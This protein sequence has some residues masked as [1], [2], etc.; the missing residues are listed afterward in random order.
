M[1]VV[2]GLGS[3]ELRGEW[4]SEEMREE[5]DI[6]IVQSEG[7]LGCHRTTLILH[8]GF[9]FDRAP[10]RRECSFVSSEAFTHSTDIYH[11][12]QCELTHSAL[13]IASASSAT[14]VEG[15]NCMVIFPRI[16]YGDDDGEKW[17]IQT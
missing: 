8:Q 6:T 5:T 10:G 13:A 11:T 7:L 17:S 2:R 9:L 4:R 14:L 1:R 3:E 16:F 12:E 15:T